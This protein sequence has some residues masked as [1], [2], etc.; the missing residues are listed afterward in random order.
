MCN[1]LKIPISLKNLVLFECQKE[2]IL[3][4]DLFIEI[5]KLRETRYDSLI[6]LEKHHVS[7]W[8]H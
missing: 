7:C 8:G 1:K 4:H 6:Q 2:A 3:F 5:E